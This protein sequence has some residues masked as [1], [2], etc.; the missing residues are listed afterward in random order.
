MQAK[1]LQ[2]THRIAMKRFDVAS[3]D[4]ERQ[5]EQAVE[6]TRFAQVEGAQWDEKEYKKRKDRPRYSINKI[7]LPLNQAVGDQ[8]QTRISIKVRPKT[9]GTD[10]EIAKTY[11][12]LIRNIET[13]SKFNRIK[14]NAFK[15]VI[16]GGIGAWYVTTEY[17]DDDTFEQ[18]IVIKKITSAATSVFL[19]SSNTDDNKRGSGWGFVIEEMANDTFEQ[20]YPNADKS[21]FESNKTNQYYNGWRNQDTTRVADYY[22]REEYSVE[23]ARMTNGKVY[24]LSEK[25]KSVFDE[26]AMEGIEIE[27]TADGEEVKRKTKRH[28]VT[29]YKMSGAEILDGPNEWAGQDIPI[30]MIYGYNIWIN[31][32]HYYR[33]MVRHAKD[34]QRVYNYATSAAIEATAQSPKDPFWITAKQ[35]QGYTAELEEF[36]TNNSPFMYYNPDPQAPGPPARTGAPS[37]QS[38]L[39]QQIAQADVDIQ[40]T[41]GRFAPSL[42]DNPAD[43]SG[44]AVIAVQQQGEAGTYELTDNLEKY[45]LQ[46]QCK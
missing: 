16:N 8:R 32:K 12:G 23:L 17:C 27:K 33:G 39:I 10:E 25:N 2:N 40:S 36:N 3:T 22:E 24:E 11:S 14:D 13:S 28:K 4:E 20:K 43:Q 45:L 26:L 42:G 7:A 35:S 31:G 15:E 37:V 34:A 5:R 6:D 21:D 19:E 9:T 38:A 46:T 44:R 41:T 18:D 29:H 1:D 30:V